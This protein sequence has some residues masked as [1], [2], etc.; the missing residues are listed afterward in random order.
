MEGVMPKIGFEQVIGQRLAVSHLQNAV[1][2]GRVSQAY[3]ISGEKGA[4]KMKLALAFAAALLCEQPKQENGGPEPCGECHSCVQIQAGSHPD[5]VLLT[6]ERVGAATKTGTLGVA[7]ARFVQADV[8][9]KP[10][11]GPYKIYIIP[12][13]E[14]LNQQAQNALLKTLEE[15]PSYVI[16][17]LATTEAN[18]I[19]VTI[20]SRC[21]RYDFRR[22]TIDTIAARLSE[23]MEKEGVDVEEKAIR[24]VAKAGDGSMRDAL[25]LLDQCIAFYLGQKLTYDKVLEVLGT[26][27][28]EI[29]SQMLRTILAGD[30]TGSIRTL[31]TLLN[32]GKELGQFVTDF[33]WYL[34][35]L[36]LVKSADETEE[37][38]D[39]STENLKLL[40]EESTMV[41]DETL[42][43]YIRVLSELSGQLRYAAQKRVLVEVALVKLCKPQMEQN[44]ESV[45]ERLRILEEKMERGI[46]M[47]VTNAPG[48]GNG[49]AGGSGA[50]GDGY[51][52]AETPQNAL[53]P[54][55]AAPAD[56]QRISASWKAIVG[57]TSGMFRQFLQSAVPKYNSETGD[58]KLFVEFADQLASIYVE[59]PEAAD[60]IRTIIEQMTGKTVEV[61]LI[62]ADQHA[63]AALST[64]SVDDALTQAIHG[65]PVEEDDESDFDDGEE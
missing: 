53:A 1:R 3:L 57:Q 59:R 48:A 60:E 21:Q 50:A 22:I 12:N 54:V 18:K 33:T 52:A 30:V 4:G 2:T 41:D 9:V 20:L 31:E 61:Q 11:Y 43:H 16:F 44:L 25:S 10:Y 46:P 63:N 49:S 51:A 64:I 32:R 42:I 27:D 40:K 14:N 55:K 45:L 28:T 38:L 23:L 15:P 39:V 5:V 24:Y 29:F 7:L 13:A 37:L 17:I 26:V 36:L 19:P 58:A 34:R 35:N 47:M 62:L 56:L 6:N 65:I 8:S